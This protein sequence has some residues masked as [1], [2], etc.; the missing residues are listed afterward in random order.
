MNRFKWSKTSQD[1]DI[2]HATSPFY[3]RKKWTLPLLVASSQYRW[4]QAQNLMCTCVL[5]AYM[6][7]CV[8]V[9]I[10]MS[11]CLCVCMCM[12]ACVCVYEGGVNFFNTTSN[13]TQY[14]PQSPSVMEKLVTTLVVSLD[15]P[16]WVGLQIRS[17]DRHCLVA[18]SQFICSRVDLRGYT[19]HCCCTFISCFLF[20]RVWGHHTPLKN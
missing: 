7:M 4:L 10:H 16:I 12:H 18:S 1:A 13:S 5:C 17:R 11:L 3:N 20:Y 2:L 6:H 14:H 15:T 9:C 8:H 19:G